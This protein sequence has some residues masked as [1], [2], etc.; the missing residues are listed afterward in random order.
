VIG[1]GCLYAVSPFVGCILAFRPSLVAFSPR[2]VKRWLSMFV[3][4]CYV[5]LSAII[6]TDDLSM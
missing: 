1:V 5:V 2:V 3:A 4:T 6:G